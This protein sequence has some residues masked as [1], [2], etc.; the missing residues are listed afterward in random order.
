MSISPDREKLIEHLPKQSKIEHYHR[1]A[2]GYLLGLEVSGRPGN[3]MSYQCDRHPAHSAK[4][5][6]TREEGRRYI[7]MAQGESLHLF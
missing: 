4:D 2:H 1:Q 6:I 3:R 5:R 7:E